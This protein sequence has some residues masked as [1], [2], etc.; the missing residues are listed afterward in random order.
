LKDEVVLH[1]DAGSNV[2][3]SGVFD[4]GD[5][6]TA[7]AEADHVVKID[8]LHFHR[9]S[10]TPLECAGALVEYDK[11]TGEWTLTCNH[12]MPASERSGWRR[13][14]ARDRQAALRHA[15]HRRR[16]RQ[17]DLPAPAVRRLCLMARKLGR[18]VQ[19]TEWRPTSTRRT[20]TATS[21]GSSTSRSAS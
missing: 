1:D 19:W 21:A 15:R 17:Q 8:K 18:P 3:W 5:V 13:R 12:Q 16:L 9:F 2:V 7:L 10:S 11:G 4:W 20:R 14:S 6:D